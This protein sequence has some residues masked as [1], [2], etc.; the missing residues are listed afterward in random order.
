LENN[1]KISRS[2]NSYILY[3]ADI[4]AKPGVELFDRDYHINQQSQQNN[5]IPSTSSKQ[6]GI[7]RAKVVY[8]TFEDK[9]LVLKHYFRGGL[10]AL[11]SKDSY[12]CFG[13]EKNRAFR[14]LRLLKKMQ[15]LNLPVPSV[16]AAHVEKKL[17]TCRVDLITE[18]IKNARTLAD[19]LNEKVFAKDVWSDI[20]AVIKKF[21]H[22]DIYHSDLNARNIL[23]ANVSEI[24]LIDFDN[25]YIRTSSET[26]KR[27]NLVRL[28]R[29]LLKFKRNQ[30]DFNFDDGDWSALIDGYGLEL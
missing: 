14:E 16:V 18:E 20:G 17:L 15:M 6:A 26:W 27:A 19:V 8:F 10:P 5:S 30:P 24:F 28:K 11:I 4:I 29:S 9:A 21:H 7:G 25:S 3:D 13:F 22:Q 1:F 2:G 12:L 23:I